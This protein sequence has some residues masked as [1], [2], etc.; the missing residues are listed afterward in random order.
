[1]NYLQKKIKT[2]M[3]LAEKHKPFI[4][5]VL[6]ILAVLPVSL[7][8]ITDVDIWW[9][10]HFGRVMLETLSLP[11]LSGTYFTP[12]TDSLSDF[13]FTFL[14]DIIFYMVYRVSGDVGL[15]LLRLG[16]VF[17]CLYFF[18][19]ITRFQYNGWTLVILM[20]FVVGTYQK[21]LIRNSL[22]ALPLTVVFLWLFFQIRFR[23]RERL[24]W[25]YPPLMGF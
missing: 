24:V 11:D 1:M 4:F 7:S 18:L 15:Q 22:F 5:W 14:G 16:S 21:Q 3:L 8:K 6:I 13:R 10:I 25:I 20:I 12:V 2:L 9:H 23:N 19:S 17:L